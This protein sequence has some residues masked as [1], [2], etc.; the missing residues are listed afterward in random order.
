MILCQSL[1]QIRL[2]DVRFGPIAD[3]PA[4]GQNSEMTSWLSRIGSKLVAATK[5]HDRIPDDIREQ[6]PLSAIEKVVFFK[7]DEWTTDLICCEVEA[8]GMVGFSTRK[9]RA[10]K[11]LSA[12]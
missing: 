12:T 5:G 7:R 4:R 8:A 11:L 1:A 9:Q 2:P 10:G 3:I 6:L